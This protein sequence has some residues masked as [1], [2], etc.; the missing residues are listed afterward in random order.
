MYVE[1]N[2]AANI[3]L[4]IFNS[5]MATRSDL[6]TDRAAIAANEVFDKMYGE[7]KTASTRRAAKKK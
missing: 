2:L 6:T 5:I 3:K 4:A 1:P 7:A